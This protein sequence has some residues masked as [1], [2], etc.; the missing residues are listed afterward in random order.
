MALSAINFVRHT[1]SDLDR[2]LGR[3]RVVR[4]YDEQNKKLPNDLRRRNPWKRKDSDSWH[5]LQQ[6]R[7][8]SRRKL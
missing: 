7:V 2:A 1:A 8:P 6:M 5:V 4:H 3:G